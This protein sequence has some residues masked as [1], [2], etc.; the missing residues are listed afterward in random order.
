M[1]KLNVRLS[2]AIATALLQ[3]TAA[4]NNNHLVIKFLEVPT[5]EKLDLLTL[6]GGALTK[7]NEARG[8]AKLHNLSKEFNLKVVDKSWKDTLINGNGLAVIIEESRTRQKATNHIK[9]A[10]A[11]T[12]EK[13]HGVVF[14]KV[15]NAKYSVFLIHLKHEKVVAEPEP[16]KEDNMGE[17]K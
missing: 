2:P 5:K 8:K 15:D 11:Y 17:A 13:N 16:S 12:T 4:L 7:V 9:D 3:F 14:D 10:I 1:K 6:Q